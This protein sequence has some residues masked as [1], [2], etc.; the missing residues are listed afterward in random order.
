[1]DREQ[2]LNMDIYILLSIVNMKLRDEFTSLDSLCENY[3]VEKEELNSRLNFAGYFYNKE[4]NQFVL[5]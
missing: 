5:S 3:D 1:M 2:L 4:T